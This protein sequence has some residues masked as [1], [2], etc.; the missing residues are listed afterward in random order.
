MMEIIRIKAINIFSA[1]MVRIYGLVVTN[2]AY[3]CIWQ[4]LL[5][6]VLFAKTHAPIE[7]VE[8]LDANLP[9]E[10]RSTIGPSLMEV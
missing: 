6:E 7:K 10:Q 8:A 4:L 5:A 2:L 9:S 3:M 1:T